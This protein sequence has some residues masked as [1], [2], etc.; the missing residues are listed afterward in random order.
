MNKKKIFIIVILV[1]VAL[2]MIGIISER[3]TH[4]VSKFLDSTISDNINHYL[5]CD[6]LPTIE[7]VNKAVQTHRDTVEKIIK[8]I[9]SRYREGDIKVTWDVKDNGGTALERD[10]DGSY[11]GVYWGEAKGCENTGKGDILFDY[12]SHS[13][14]EI[15]EKTLGTNFFGT[16]YRGENH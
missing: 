9:G 1:L 3:K 10:N 16:P 12:L 13:D 15:I 4:F 5:S 7:E 11:F 2:L 6:Q 14:R 8:E